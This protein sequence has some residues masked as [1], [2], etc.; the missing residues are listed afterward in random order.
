M[1]TPRKSLLLRSQD[2][3][4]CYA[5]PGRQEDAHRFDWNNG[6][7]GISSGGQVGHDDPLVVSLMM[8]GGHVEGVGKNEMVAGCREIW[9]DESKKKRKPKMYKEDRC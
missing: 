2:L 1:V 6:L 4:L 3:Y 8:D 7:A 9:E 5:L